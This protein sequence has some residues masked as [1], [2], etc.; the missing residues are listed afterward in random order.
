MKTLLRTSQF[1][2][3]VKRMEKRG[4]DFSDF[5]KVIL[6]LI[7]GDNLPIDCV[8]HPLMGKYMGTRE[9]HIEPD[10]LLVYQSSLEELVLIRTGTH[11]D[12]FNN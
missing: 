4:K 3:D 5:K 12:L 7:N 1:K 2:K 11:S 6:I 9:C 10:W 8:D